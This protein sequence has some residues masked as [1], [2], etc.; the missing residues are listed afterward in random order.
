MYVSNY[1]VLKDR[2][3]ERIPCI[4]TSLLL[5]CF[6]A[7]RAWRGGGLSDCPK[8]GSHQLMLFSLPMIFPPTPDTPDISSQIC[9]TL[10]Q[11]PRISTLLLKH[12]NLLLSEAPA[13]TVASEIGFR[14]QSFA[15]LNSATLPRRTCYTNINL[16]STL[17][18]LC[19]SR[20]SQACPGM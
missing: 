4:E 11:P 10:F 12:R 13:C 7:V 9:N 18:H 14:L 19:A 1:R 3:I 17:P 5:A 20:A 15:N 8:V 16:A 2:M 6:A